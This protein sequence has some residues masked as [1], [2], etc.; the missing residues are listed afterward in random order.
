MSR[1]PHTTLSDIFKIFCMQ[2][3]DYRDHVMQQNDISS[4]YRKLC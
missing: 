2:E 3:G 4:Q 1:E